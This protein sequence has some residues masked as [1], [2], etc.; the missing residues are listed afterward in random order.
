MGQLKR[1]GQDQTIERTRQIDQGQPKGQRTRLAN[2][3][4]HYGTRLKK[5]A[6]RTRNKTT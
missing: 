2:Q 1:R 4:Q 6:M 3:G 5:Y